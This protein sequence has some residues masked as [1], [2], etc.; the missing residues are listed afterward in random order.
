VDDGSTDNTAGEAERAQARVVRLAQNQGKG[1]AL[2]TGI[3]ASRGRWLVFLDADGQDDPAEIPKLLGAVNDNV[4]LVNGS[5]F[6]GELKKGA[7]SRANWVG[8]VM[9]T[10]IFDLC[11][12]ARITDTQA[13]FRVMDGDIARDLK[14]VSQEYE[15]ETEILAKVLRRGLQVVE[16]PV[17][18]YQ[19]A[20]GHTDFRR[21]RNGLRILK[22]IIRERVR[23]P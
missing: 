16:I 8:N 7:I 19:R 12:G 21:I 9:I 2:R 4:A 15:I 10:G 23:R 18:R 6:M 1:V 22:T 20:A 17:T 3:Q 11:F 5:R 13:G 14:L